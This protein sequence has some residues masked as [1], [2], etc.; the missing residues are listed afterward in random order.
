MHRR[1]GAQR[2]SARRA[3]VVERPASHWDEYASVF[4][5]MLSNLRPLHV[6]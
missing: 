5:T 4:S 3:P 2:C 1:K 6:F